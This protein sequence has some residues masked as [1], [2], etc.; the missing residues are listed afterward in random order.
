MRKNSVYPLDTGRNLNVHKTFRKRPGN[1]MNVLFT[2]YLRPV[3]RGYNF[4]TSLKNVA[5]VL[6]ETFPNTQVI[7]TIMIF[8]PKF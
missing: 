1:L 8:Y 5:I 6:L 3:F 2:F 7:V 4:F